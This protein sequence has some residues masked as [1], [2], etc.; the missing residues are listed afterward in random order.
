MK[1]RFYTAPY[2]LRPFV[3]V[4]QYLCMDMFQA[5][6]DPEYYGL[7]KRKTKGS[8]LYEIEVTIKRINK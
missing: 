7:N 4:K 8:A 2:A 3:S 5:L 1:K 6:D